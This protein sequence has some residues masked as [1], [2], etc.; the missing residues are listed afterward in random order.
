MCGLLTQN[1]SQ[2]MIAAATRH[3]FGRLSKDRTAGRFNDNGRD[4]YTSIDRV[5]NNSLTAHRG[6]ASETRRRHSE[7]QKHGHE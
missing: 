2:A 3:G 6:V 4:A 5:G 1:A 7:D